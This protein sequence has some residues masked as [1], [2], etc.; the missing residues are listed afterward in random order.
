M[1]HV[2]DNTLK[3]NFGAAYVAAL[4]SSECLVRPVASDT[5]IGVDLYC[6]SVRTRKPYLHFWIQVKAGDQCRVLKSGESASYAFKKSHLRYWQRQPVPVFAALVPTSWPV[7]DDPSIY[8]INVTEHLVT[9]G[10]P[11]GSTKSLR[12][13]YVWNAGNRAEIRSFLKKIVPRTSAR[14]MCMHGVCAPLPTLGLEYV[15]EYPEVPITRHR[16]AT[17]GQIRRTAANAIMSMWMEG[18]LLGSN[19][20]ARRVLANVIEQFGGDM[21]W[22]NFMARAISA[23]ADRYFA[24][25]IDLYR[26]AKASIERDQN[27]KKKAIFKRHLTE[28]EAQLAKASRQEPP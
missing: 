12:S 9:Q 25:A 2:S 19:A 28:I 10:L 20:A 1:A 23:H 27:A 6:E 3:G 11:R 21:H 7:S 24:A 18:Q 8:V 16:K 14:M 13:D 15:R 22:E 26:E 4:L 5:D 17:L